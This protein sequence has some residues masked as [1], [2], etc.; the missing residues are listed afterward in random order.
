M[1][2]VSLY[3]YLVINLNWQIGNFADLLYSKN[4]TRTWHWISNIKH[5]PKAYMNW[6]AKKKLD[7]TLI[8][9]R[10]YIYQINDGYVIWHSLWIVGDVYPGLSIIVWYGSREFSG[11][12]NKSYCCS[13]GFKFGKIQGWLVCTNRTPFHTSTNSPPACTTPYEQVGFIAL[14][15]LLH[16]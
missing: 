7:N 11:V 16:P 12:C 1:P 9:C 15:Y 14:C 5:L 10:F 6:T 4:F 8:T 13:L 3:F 2:L